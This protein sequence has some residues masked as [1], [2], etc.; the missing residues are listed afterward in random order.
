MV[1]PIIVRAVATKA[2]AKKAAKKVANKAFNKVASTMNKKLTT[3]E[4]SRMAQNQRRKLQ[5]RLANELSNELGYKVTWNSATD[6]Y[7]GSSVESDLAKQIYGDI[8]KLKSKKVEGTNKRKGYS[9]DLNEM[10]DKI[11]YQYVQGSQ[12]RRNEMFKNK[13]NQASAKDEE[14][15][16]LSELNEM[17]V[18][19][20]YAATYEM[21]KGTSIEQNRNIDI[22]REFGINDLETIYKLITNE[23]KVDDELFGLKASDF[24]FDDEMLFK[25]WLQQIDKNVNLKE[26][27]RMYLEEMSGLRDVPESKYKSN[28]MSNI[29]IRTSGIKRYKR[30]RYAS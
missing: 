15:K 27:R 29:K 5:R 30:R 16:K 13:I 4:A 10:E 18:H 20:F 12:R 11:N 17:D 2:A 21:W 1:A 25:Q 14:G 3:R 22:M 7:E 19:G 24:G 9:V 8:Q 28:S 26:L 23:G 6:V